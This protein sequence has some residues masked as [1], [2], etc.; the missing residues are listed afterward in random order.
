[1]FTVHTLSELKIWLIEN[2]KTK[3][4]R[5]PLDNNKFAVFP[6]LH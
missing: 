6:L 1:M 2:I 4:V 3:Y 5:L